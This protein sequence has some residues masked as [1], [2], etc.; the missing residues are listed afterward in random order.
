MDFKL[1]GLLLLLLGC[2]GYSF[3]LL[4]REKRKENYIFFGFNL[5]LLSLVYSV[6]VLRVKVSGNSVGIEIRE[7][8][9]KAEDAKREVAQSASSAAQLAATLAK[10]SFVAADGASRFGGPPDEHKKLL[11]KYASS[12]KAYYPGDLNKEVDAVLL[13]L[14]QQIRRRHEQENKK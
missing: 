3:R 2:F 13:D 6:G 7:E 9:Q 8:I 14:D 5:L 4:H 11:R 10:M 12:L 1:G